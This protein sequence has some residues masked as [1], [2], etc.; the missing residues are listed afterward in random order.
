VALQNAERYERARR[1]AQRFELLY[2]AGQELGNLPISLKSNKPMLL[3]YAMRKEQSQS[4]VSH[5][6]L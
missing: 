4:Q 5:S 1:E 6:P 3:C 2:E